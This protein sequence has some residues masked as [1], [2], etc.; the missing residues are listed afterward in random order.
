MD[1][2]EFSRL[3]QSK[4]AQLDRLMRH[5][6]PVIAGRMAKDHFQDNFRRGGFVNNGL[7]PWAAAR[8]LSLGYK[9]ASMNNGTLLSGRKH[10]FKSIQYT[11]GEY[12]VTIYN[13][14]LYA[15][16]HNWGGEIQRTDRMRKYAWHRFYEACGVSKNNSGKGSLS[17]EAIASNPEAGFWKGMALSR[18]KSIKIPQRQFIG[19]SQELTDAI[20]NRLEEEIQ[21]ILNI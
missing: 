15:P 1:I 19:E 11:P 7:H 18:K 20:K 16:I 4:Q 12:R 13:D 17:K 3:I 9:S 6:M 10:L 5:N 21:K 14:V 8:R 2:S